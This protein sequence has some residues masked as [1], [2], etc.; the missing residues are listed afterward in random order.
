MLISLLLAQVANA[1]PPLSLTGLTVM[2]LSVG[3]VLCL[4]S[5]CLYT[6]MTLPPVER[7]EDEFHPPRSMSM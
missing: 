3:S 7:E 1:S 2:V 6:V 4:L 5:F